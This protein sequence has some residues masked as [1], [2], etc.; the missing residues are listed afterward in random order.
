VLRTPIRLIAAAGVSGAIYVV[1]RVER[2]GS[3]LSP[4]RHD[5]YLRTWGRLLLGVLGVRVSS[6]PAPES[7]TLPRLVVS[8]HRSTIDILILL[9]LF[10]GHLLSRADVAD[11][12]VMG[13][14]ARE[15]GTVLVDRDDAA[16]R[17]AAVLRIRERLRGGHTVCVFPEGTTFYGDEVRPFQG[18]AFIAVAR[19]KGE[20]VPVGIAY[21]NDDA[22]F[23]DETMGVHLRRLLRTRTFRAAVAVG[24]P[25]VCAGLGVTRLRDRAQAEVQGLV[26]QARAKLSARDASSR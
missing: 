16:S 15:A 9:R 2:R 4:S 19:E 17:T 3:E 14:L 22:I 24:S 10:G 11:W 8:N 23:G 20:V 12:P 1:R 26:H 6:D 25:I 21:E 5:A 18:G 13:A 7:T